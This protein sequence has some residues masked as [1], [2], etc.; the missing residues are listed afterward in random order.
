VPVYWLLESTCLPFENA[1]PYA[2]CS[3]TIQRCRSSLFPRQHAA[4][5]LARFSVPPATFPSRGPPSF[6]LRS[7]VVSICLRVSMISQFCSALH[8]IRQHR[9]DGMRNVQKQ[10]DAVPA[11]SQ[12]ACEQLAQAAAD[13]AQRVCLMNSSATHHLDLPQ[14]QNSFASESSHVAASSDVGCSAPASIPA[15][16]D[17]PLCKAHSNAFVS[18]PPFY[19][20]ITAILLST[21][22]SG[23]P[24]KN[25][26]ICS[27]CKSSSPAP[28][29]ET[30][31]D[32]LPNYSVPLIPTKSRVR[33]MSP[34]SVVA[35]PSCNLRF[36][37][38]SVLVSA[39][40][41]RVK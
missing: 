1:C 19:Q 35:F 23:A 11:P 20:G 10:P 8:I 2:L 28:A 12:Q 18:P 30:P 6:A 39:V 38:L 22:H 17:A 7:F 14:L 31:Q 24:A 40:G 34:G 9:L 4:F 16:L 3:V 37:L 21:E 29:S 36:E 26:P 25:P 33:V 41:R 32:P 27:K 13:A 5:T 15:V